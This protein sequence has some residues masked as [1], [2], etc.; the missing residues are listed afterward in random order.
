MKVKINADLE[1]TFFDV[2]IL[3][4]AYLISLNKYCTRNARE[5][6]GSHAI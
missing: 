4:H 1:N 2:I 5:I 6:T 3:V